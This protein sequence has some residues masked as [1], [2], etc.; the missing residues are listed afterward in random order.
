MTKPTD[1]VNLSENRAVLQ[2]STGTVRL[3][4]KR[5]GNE[6]V[7]DDLFQEGSGKIRMALSEK[8][9]LKEAV[10]INTTGGLTDGDVFSTAIHW[11]KDTT[12]SVTTQAAERIYR[13]R[14]GDAHLKTKLRMEQGATALWLPQETIMFDHARL[15]RSNGISLVG[16]ARLIAVEACIFGRTAMGEKVTTGMM[17]DEWHIRHDGRLIFADRFCLEGDI[18]AELNHP[19]IA[20]GAI[21]MATIVHVSPNNLIEALRDVI[22]SR[23]C[24]GGVTRLGPLTLTRLF[25][26]NA[27][28]LREVIVLLLDVLISGTLPKHT[29]SLLPRVWSL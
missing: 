2:R 25:A 9:R 7:L 26:K 28:E 15:R 21:A 4:F 24:A 12:A 5:R 8:G 11:Q 22:D 16:D 23:T 6:T 20:G 17:R 18:E 3:G 27:Q 13:S 29:G 14:G 19:A 10:I 1:K